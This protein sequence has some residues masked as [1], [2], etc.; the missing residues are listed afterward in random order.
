MSAAAG[1]T[2]TRDASLC[3]STEDLIR[4]RMPARRVIMSARTP[5]SSV[6]AG[7]HASR[8]RGRGV[9]YVESRAYEVGDD[10]RDLDWRVTAR[11]GKPHTKVFQEERER[12]VL[13]IIDGAA[14]MYF[15]TQGA[16]KV[17]QASRLA[18]LIGWAAV[19]RGDRIGAL[20]SRPGEHREVRPAGGRRG[21]LRLISILTQVLARG[22][23]PDFEPATEPVDSMLERAR[24]LARP[25]SLI[26]LISDF[27]R[28]G[29]NF[30]RHMAFLRRHSDLV[31]CRVRDPLERN[32]P[33]QG[34]YPITNG[35]S[36]GVMNLNREAERRVFSKFLESQ[37][38]SFVSA[39]NR[40]G[41]NRLELKTTDDVTDALG[42]LFRSR[43]SR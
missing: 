40:Q 33:P 19:R 31:A 38:A 11:T 2:Q 12:P 34:T 18:A 35:H 29:D 1:T 28:M 39:C 10:I 30:E 26:F 32:L 43:D 5:V 9:D 4:L 36:Q 13:V 15:A 6:I 25:G 27:Y 42:R 14:S 24:R 22:E 21:V 3:V 7:V 8:F 20:I 16:L 17:V 41:V 23:A 37:K